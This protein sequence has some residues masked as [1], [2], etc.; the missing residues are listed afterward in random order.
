MNSICSLDYKNAKKTLGL[1]IFL[2]LIS[3]ALLSPFWR[4]FS[5]GATETSSSVSPH[6]TSD[7]SNPNARSR[8]SDAFGRLP[9]SFEANKGQTDP[10][11]LFLT[12]G[13]GYG[14]FLTADGALFSLNGL[15]TPL[16][17]RLQGAAPT[18][19]VSGLD[20]LPGK[21]NYLIGNKSDQWRTDISTYARVR[22]E[23]IYP[24]VDLVFYGNQRQLEYDVVVAPQASFKQIGLTFE[25][26]KLKLNRR[27]DLVWRAGAREITLLRPRAYQEIGG[28]RRSISARYLLRANREV[29]FQIGN[30]DRT[31]PLVIDP[32]L[33]YSTYLGGSNADQAQSIA[34]DASGNAYITGQTSS[35]NFPTVPSLPANGTDAFVTKLN[36]AGTALIYSTILGGSG[37][38]IGT[39][40]ACDDSGN[41]YIAG[42]TSSSDFPV[43]TALHPTFG[44]VA[45]AFIVQLNASGSAPVFSTYLGGRSNDFATSIAVDS[46]GD[47]YITGSTSSSNF[48]TTNPLQASRAG[49][50]IFKTINAAGNWAASD[51]GLLGSTVTDLVFDPSN[52]SI[53]YAASETGIYKTTDG[54]M[55]WTALGGQTIFTISKLAI[56]PSNPNIIY[57][58]TTGGMLKSTDGGNSLNAINNGINPQFVRA[59][60]IDPITPAT[61]YAAGISNFLFKSTDGGANWTSSFLNSV[62]SVNALLIDPNTPSTI[63][64][65]TNRGVFKSTNSGS[66]WTASN[67]GFPFSNVTVNALAFDKTNNLLYAATNA[68]IFKSANAA[69]NWTNINGNLP[70]LSTAL[71]APD[72][73][74]SS[75]VYMVVSGLVFKTIDAGATWTLSNTGVPNTNASALLVNPTQPAT[76][77][78]ASNAGSDAFVTKLSA[79]GAS[80]VYSTYLG[81]NL[82]DAGNGI[83][84]DGSG[85]AYVVGTTGSLNFPTANAIQPTRD[86]NTGDAFVTKLNSS[87]SALV[88]STFLGGNS[89]DTARGVAVDTS[90]NAYVTGTTLSTNFPT[91]NAFQ[92][93]NPSSS[94]EAFVTKINPAGSSL[95]FSTYLGGSNNDDGFDI[96]VDATGSVYVVGATSS[97]NFP[98]A[99]ALQPTLKGSSDAFVTKFA[100]SGMSLVYSTYLG[101]TDVEGGLSLALDSSNNAYVVGTTSSTDFPTLNPLQSANGGI[102]DAFVAKL[103]SAP[104]LAL[105]ISDAPDPVNF[106]A[107]LTYTIN[108]TNNGDVPATGVT[109]SDTLPAGST[110]VSV[111]TTV[112]SCSGTSTITCALGTLNPGAAATITLVSKPPSI[113][114]INNTASVT[115][116]ETDAF[117]PNNT[118]TTQTLVDFADLVITKNV[119]QSLV[120]PGG[121]LTYS[122]IA[123]NKGV[124]PATVTVTD[125]LPAGTSLT[126]CATAS[127]IICGGSGDNVSVQIPSLAPNASEAVLLTVGVSASATAGTLISNT[128]SVSSPLPDPDTSNNSSSV[129]VTVA[130]IPV[131]QKSNGIIAF[132]SDRAISPGGQPS[133][134]YTIKPDG[135]G[136]A[137]F[138]NVTLNAGRPVWSPDGSKLA[139]KFSNFSFS[140]INIIN[141]DGTGLVKVVSDLATNGRGMSWSPSGTQIAFV[142]LGQ[143]NDP[144][145]IGGINI[146]NTDGS[147]SY[148]VPGSPMSLD[149]VDWSPD[150][151]KFVISNGAVISVINADGTGLTQLTT[152]QATD[153]GP[154]RDWEPHWSPDGN[155]IIFT[156]STTNSNSIYRMNADGSNIARLFNFS[157]LQADWSPDGLSVVLQQLNE[158]CTANIDGTNFK[159]LTNNLFYDGNP[160]WQELPNPNPTP[161]PTPVPTFSISG[162]VTQNNGSP[163]FTQIQI[164]GP[165]S[166]VR[167]TNQSGDF[168][169]VNLPAGQY[170]LTPLNVFFTFEPASRAITI[171]N[172]NVTGMNFVATFSPANVTGHVRDNNGNPL[173]GIRITSNGGFPEG[174]TL[175]DANGFYSFPDVQRHR[176]YFI[177]PDPFTAYT[178][179]PDGQLIADLTSSQVVDFVGTKQ[180]ANVIAGRVVEASSGQG[181]AGIEVR[182]QEGSAL[183]AT[184]ITEANGNYSFGERKSNRS[185][186]VFIQPH[187]TFDFEPKMDP[188]NPSAN[189][190]IASL[191]AD[192]N[193]IFRGTRRNTV[194]FATS[195]FSVPEDAGSKE[196]VVTRTG[197]VASA[198]TVNYATSDTAGLAACTIVNGKASERCDYETAVGT[199]RFAAGETSKSFTV[200][201]VDDAH[202]E[203]NETF[204]VTLSGAVGA[205]IN[206]Q[207]ST[208]VTIIDNDTTPSTQN[209]ID[210]VQTFVTQQYIDFLGRLP[211]SIGLANW[212]ATL[213]GCPNGGFGENDNP[214][215]DRVHVSAGFFLSDEFRGRGYWA[216]R[217][218]EV[219]F[220]RRPLYAEFVPDMAQVGG[221]QSPASELLSKAAYTDAFVQRSEFTNRYNGL[222]NSAYVNALEQNAEITLVNKAALIAALDGNTKTRGGV[223]REI[224][225]SKDVED[226]FLIRAF[227]AMQYFGYLRRDPDTIGYNNW[228]TTLTADPS[229]FR[230]MIFGFLFSTE[231][232][233]RFGNN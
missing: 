213:N 208:T 47:A 46:G 100:P 51:S 98:V 231:Y 70:G 144:N 183:A 193:L 142:G 21:V 16:R 143:P 44:G 109:V 138:P 80:Q 216:Y 187:Q 101:G 103:R 220:D 227:V 217:F 133:G 102:R 172:A 81:G 140:D 107:D 113:R 125:T 148:K 31:Q 117:P 58:A 145:S 8:A 66:T 63:Y 61:L 188:Q 229:N 42:Q 179:V 135:T 122:L 190:V 162:R 38:D 139:F 60:A 79:G 50:S 177:R 34:V 110:F 5:M 226:R 78:L 33:S 9:L 209:P 69:G 166:A 106:G 25:G 212:M 82:N 176:N 39:S 182:L 153:D 221:P 170:S 71:V 129:D 196:I 35:T 55:N 197:D 160:S 23:Q 189:F 56:D 215:C 141:A 165:A 219:G 180:P 154:T 53:I 2:A 97:N 218:Y 200:P 228:V 203:G 17:M 84:V 115:L 73:T 74:S 137:M 37:I 41:A 111:N 204:T 150:G 202:V 157:G 104:E 114:T 185:Y 126:K 65:G 1:L 210:D 195:S 43:F 167:L 85:N 48:P 206:G 93:T 64:A 72:P 118:A 207:S 76:L 28:K 152:V 184:A 108:V 134:V 194:Q 128:A 130:I 30:Y 211:D 163:L 24:G 26:G 12:R 233:G 27:G 155:K 127:G 7:S 112:G 57:A 92:A 90:G 158:I 151:S 68:G 45:D 10:Q 225:E 4:V 173:S 164:S 83:A 49:N 59:V 205:T 159:C 99:G 175:T 181:L 198:A 87:G 15:A 86:E 116:N 201:I 199:L 67:T 149:T 20:E 174:S 88:Y 13:Q 120:A 94:N 222:S 3:T 123:K 223:L 18:P 156:R 178:F 89:N 54:G 29:G 105:T 75:I 52:A 169:F 136:E 132:A 14:L 40:I 192:Q 147:G 124:I 230:H 214:S 121:K 96:A 62:N 6:K 11:V 32:V 131:A 19:R 95:V 161:T 91:A 22:Y 224:I 186:T 191:T 146:A 232:R 77:Y 168:D 119:A 171:T 36:A